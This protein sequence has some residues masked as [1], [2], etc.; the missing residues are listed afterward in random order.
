MLAATTAD[1]LFVTTLSVEGFLMAPVASAVVGGL[2][3]AVVLFMTVLDTG[4]VILFG[5]QQ[6]A[7]EGA[8]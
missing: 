8:S 4:K 5:R 3:V 7:K 6:V 1:L 2:L